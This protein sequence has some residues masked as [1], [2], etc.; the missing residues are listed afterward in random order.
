MAFRMSLVIRTTG[1]PL[2]LVP[3]LRSVVLEADPSLPLDNVATMESRVSASVAQPRF[4]AM[5]LGLFAVLALALAAIGIYGI[6][7]YTVSQRYREIGVRRA[8]GARPSHIMGLVLRQGMVLTG[9]GLVA[10]LAGAV[11]LTRLVTSLLFGVE[12]LDAW[13][14]VSVPVVLGLVALL[15][16]FLP[17]LRATKVDPITALRYE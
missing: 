3:F 15:A 6:L 4:Y 17:A 11:A 13:T 9:L 7:S 12:P 16:C 10:G 8:L 5:I 1:D 2:E 14:F